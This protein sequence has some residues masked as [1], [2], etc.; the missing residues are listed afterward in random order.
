MRYRFVGPSKT[1]LRAENKRVKV[2]ILLEDH[3]RLYDRA[4]EYSKRETYELY[5]RG[6]IFG[7][8]WS[9]NLLGL[10]TPFGV[11]LGDDEIQLL[12]GS[13]GIL[14]VDNEG[15]VLVVRER[16]FDE[17]YPYRVNLVQS[18]HRGIDDIIFASNHSIYKYGMGSL[19]MLKSGSLVIPM[20]SENQRIYKYLFDNL[21][22]LRL[23]ES[24]K[25]Y[26]LVNVEEYSDF[27]VDIAIKWRNQTI[28]KFKSGFTVDRKNGLMS[29]FK[30]FKWDLNFW[31][32]EARDVLPKRLS[33]IW[34]PTDRELLVVSAEDVDRINRSTP[35]MDKE[36][37]EGLGYSRGNVF[38]YQF[39]LKDVTPQL[40][41]AI[42]NLKEY[43]R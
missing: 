27:R 22:D 31:D 38:V 30:I 37:V 1:V 5:R 12:W 15:N 24:Y 10:V 28:N 7:R 13:S 3:N 42:F 29:I 35:S 11:E 4:R 8:M 16:G 43:V 41:G 17:L 36:I 14:H 6:Q 40:R 20:I 19:M 26:R 21:E 23:S 34:I 25:D 33:N 2:E 18:Y 9:A 39:K 32:I